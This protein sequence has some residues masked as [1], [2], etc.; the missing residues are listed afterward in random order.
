[1]NEHELL[2]IK[3]LATRLELEYILCRREAMIA[4]NQLIAI[5]EEGQSYD[6]DSFLDLGNEIQELIENMEGLK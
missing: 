4:A 6:D 3:L 2:S 1:M 5:R